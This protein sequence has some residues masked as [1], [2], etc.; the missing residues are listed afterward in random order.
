MDLNPEFEEPKSSESSNSPQDSQEF[1]AVP[2]YIKKIVKSPFSSAVVA[3]EKVLDSSFDRHFVF[4]NTKFMSSTDPDKPDPAVQK[5]QE[6]LNNVMSSITEDLEKM[7]SME[8]FFD[9]CLFQIF[10]KE[11]LLRKGASTSYIAKEWKELEKK[12]KN[13]IKKGSKYLKGLKEKDFEQSAN[14]K[15][16]A[17]RS[18]DI[19]KGYIELLINRYRESLN[20]V[21]SP[22]LNL[23]DKEEDREFLEWFYNSIEYTGGEI[24]EVEGGESEI[25]KKKRKNKRND[26]K[27]LKKFLKW[28]KSIFGI[29]LNIPG[30]TDGGD[31]DDDEE[32]EKPMTKQEML[33]YLMKKNKTNNPGDIADLIKKEEERKRIE[34]ENKK[35][36]EAKDLSRVL[37]SL[38]F[39]QKDI[40]IQDI[41]AGNLAGV[42]RYLDQKVEEI[43]KNYNKDYSSIGDISKRIEKKCEE[44]GL[45]DNYYTMDETS[46]FDI[47][48]LG[49]TFKYHKIKYTELDKDFFDSIGLGEIRDDEELP[50]DIKDILN[51]LGIEFKDKIN[52]RSF[53]DKA[54]KNTIY[55]YMYW[56]KYLGMATLLSLPRLVKWFYTPP[57]T[58]PV[59][60]LPIVVFKVPVLKVACVIGIGIA[61][62]GTAPLIILVNKDNV[63]KSWLIPVTMAVDIAYQIGKMGVD[64]ARKLLTIKGITKE[65]KLK[66]K[67]AGLEKA[68]KVGREKEEKLRKELE[69]YKQKVLRYVEKLELDKYRPENQIPGVGSFNQML[70][71][72]KEKA[73]AMAG[74]AGAAA[75]GIAGQAKD[76]GKDLKDKAGLGGDKKSTNPAD[77]SNAPKR[78]TRSDDSQTYGGRAKNNPGPKKPAPSLKVPGAEWEEPDD[79]PEDYDD[80]DDD[81]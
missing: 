25:E 39:S 81:F 50:D 8:E 68:Y 76:A 24:K 31:N 64:G 69:E 54:T 65:Q 43:I 6:D 67:L 33:E 58:L 71:S 57:L 77:V 16:I 11:R 13:K 66:L 40:N 51:D 62:M 80:D 27:A 56:L 47:D 17:E 53:V 19:K 49:K 52:D 26:N 48:I 10:T 9:K 45:K 7:S 2:K 21:I 75:S 35:K 74:T 12:K 46:F 61:G 41:K 20:E 42:Q 32:D 14:L 63:D 72:T 37:K 79:Y 18:N 5:I 38:G 34:E 29:D 60:Y 78:S 15:N 36:R 30:L 1:S 73:K 28:F 3:E 22:L 4:K 59:I 70:K 44:A 23:G 55:D